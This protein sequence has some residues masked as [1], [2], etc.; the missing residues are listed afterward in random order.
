MEKL[1]QD[2]DL[3]EILFKEIDLVQNVINRMSSNSFLVKGWAITLI[4]ASLLFVSSAPFYYHFVTFL[5]L[6]AFWFL[7][8][9]F[10]HTEKLYRALYDWLIKNRAMSN[11][12]LLDLNTQNLKKRFP[13]V[14]SA[15]RLMFSKT[16]FTFY[17]LL[18]LI[19][20]AVVIADLLAMTQKNLIIFSPV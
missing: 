10:L 2:K 14:K 9:F 11:D 1:A 19:I 6:I 17:G 20:L 3:R 18:L 7:D 12:F 4:V 13:K 8:A 5:P 15:E 16:L